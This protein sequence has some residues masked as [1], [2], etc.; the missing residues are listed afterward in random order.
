MG[1]GC[2]PLLCL[3]AANGRNHCI[4]AG[5]SLH[6]VA[7]DFGPVSHTRVRVGFRPQYQVL[8]VPRINLARNI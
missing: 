3:A 8:Y 1:V 4:Q 5:L 6:G 2:V 7:D